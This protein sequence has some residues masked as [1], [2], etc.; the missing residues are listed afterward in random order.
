MQLHQLSPCWILWGRSPRD[1]FRAMGLFGSGLQFCWCKSK[2]NKG[3]GMGIR[4]CHMPVPLGFTLPPLLHLQPAPLPLPIPVPPPPSPV[5]STA[6]PPCQLSCLGCSSLY[7]M[8]I[9]KR[10]ATVVKPCW[11]RSANPFDIFVTLSN[12]HYSGTTSEMSGHRG[13]LA[14]LFNWCR[15]SGIWSFILCSWQWEKVKQILTE[16]TS[17]QS[18]DH[19]QFFYRS[20]AAEWDIVIPWISILPI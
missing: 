1:S 11:D 20:A 5:P 8:L 2:E 18:R 19:T 14:D 3:G 15:S 9:Y 4:S 13:L 17:H 12:R 7:H 16:F 10:S 6:H